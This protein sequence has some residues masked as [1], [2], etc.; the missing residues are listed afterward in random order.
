MMRL[1]AIMAIAILALPPLPAQGRSITVGVCGDNDARVP[2]P[3]KGTDDPGC[4]R[5]GCHAAPNRRKKAND[6]SDDSCC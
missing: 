3:V 4:C 6:R 2:I 5:K 1:A